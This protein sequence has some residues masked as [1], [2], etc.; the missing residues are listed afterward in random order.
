M[1]EITDIQTQNFTFIEDDHTREYTL[2]ELSALVD[3]YHDNNDV[4]ENEVIFEAWVLAKMT[5]SSAKYNFVSVFE[6]K[7]FTMEKITVDKLK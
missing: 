1:I 3:D 6:N 7:K 2:E 4:K 5:V